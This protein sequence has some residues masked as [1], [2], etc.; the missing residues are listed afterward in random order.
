MRLTGDL[1]LIFLGFFAQRAKGK[2]F[3]PARD[4]AIGGKA[5]RSPQQGEE[6]V[7]MLG[8]NALQLLVSAN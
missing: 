4:T 1:D 6:T 2:E 7:H 3:V 8:R 5:Q